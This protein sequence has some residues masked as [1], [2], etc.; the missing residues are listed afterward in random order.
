MSLT[1]NVGSENKIMQHLKDGLTTF[2]LLIL[3]TL[4]AYLYYHLSN[5]TTNIATIYILYVFLVARFTSGYIW[6]IIAS[7][8]G[9]LGVNYLFTYP[10]FAFNFTIT[11]YPF[12]FL[13]MLIIA[14]ITSTLTAHTKEQARIKALGEACLNKLNEINKQLIIA[15]STSQIIELT[16]NY[17]TSTANISC[18]FYT[19]DPITDSAPIS[20][21]IN[22]E[23]ELTFSSDYERAIAH[24]AYVTQKPSGLQAPASN[25]SCFYL[26]VVSHHRIWGILGLFASEN[27]RFIQEN[28]NFFTLM[29]P[30]MALAFERQ[31]LSDEHQSLAIE[32]EKEKMRANLLRAVSHDLRTPL[33]SIIGSSSTYIDNTSQLNESEKL[34]LITQIYED[35]NWLLHMVENLLS[36]TR[37]VKETAKVIKNN[38]LLEE[39]I[40]EAVARI[41][42]RY[43]ESKVNVSIPDD[44]IIVPMDATLIEQV[45]INLVENAIKHAKAIEP[46]EVKAFTSNDL[47][48]VQVI[49]DGVGI[50]PDRLPTLFDGTSL[51]HNTSIDTSKGIGIGLSI[52]KTII[53]AHSGTIQAKN[54]K[55]GVIFSFTLPLKETAIEGADQND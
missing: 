33:T 27:L 34:K 39:V 51:D 31:A 13:G 26:P 35:S 49:D 52:C 14:V 54:L 19:D 28:L 32:S 7:I 40:S 55:K 45:I 48:Y 16:L 20:L 43:P 38:E 25:G 21:L 15:D 17:V 30:Q 37:I 4:L 42:Q 24:L 44:V 23:D 47:V 3:S 10:F 5:N 46:I 53:S 41:K 8:G 50:P 12:T 1:D 29:L 6:S 9:M 22:A 2:S 36:V 18:I 11:G